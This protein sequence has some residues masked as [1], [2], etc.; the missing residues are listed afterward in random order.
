MRLLPLLFLGAALGWL[1]SL[2]CGAPD[3]RDAGER[4]AQ[5]GARDDLA[6]ALDA[7]ALEK[8]SLLTLAK[9]SSWLDTR[10]Y[11]SKAN[12]TTARQHLAAWNARLR[13]AQSLV[14]PVVVS[15][16]RNPGAPAELDRSDVEAYN[17]AVAEAE[18]LTLVY[19]GAHFLAGL[20]RG[21][22]ARAAD[23]LPVELSAFDF[24]AGFAHECRVL[25]EHGLLAFRNAQTGEITWPSAPKS[26]VAVTGVNADGSPIVRSREHHG[27]SSALDPAT[28][29]WEVH[30]GKLRS[31]SASVYDPVER[32]VLHSDSGMHAGIGGVFNPATGKVEWR[33]ASDAGFAGYYDPTQGAVQWK[34]EVNSGVACIWRIDG[35]YFTSHGAYGFEDTTYYPVSNGD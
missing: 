15:H 27:L 12:E 35:Q 2:G 7:A 11:I 26:S 32:K 20:F 4:S 14:R 13:E 28:G 6:A 1:P 17:A 5:G 10:Y 19:N 9:R 25:K 29:A 22:S 24:V 3:G 21:V 8:S 23:V 16:R 31:S 33:S 34:S 18:G 30:E